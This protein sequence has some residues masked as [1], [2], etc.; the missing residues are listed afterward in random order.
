MNMWP[1]GV[2][3]ILPGPEQMAQMVEAFRDAEDAEFLLSF[4][5]ERDAAFAKLPMESYADQVGDAV[6]SRDI[7]ALSTMAYGRSCACLGKRGREPECPCK[8]LAVEVRRQI[9]PAGLRYGR[10]VL[11]KGA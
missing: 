6:R 11:V 2:P 1:D 4:S 9:V 10:V 7:L 8:M 5:E 3:E